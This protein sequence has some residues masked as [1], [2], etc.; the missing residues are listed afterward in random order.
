MASTV[1]NDDTQGLRAAMR[2]HTTIPWGTTWFI[3]VHKNNRCVQE[4][5]LLIP[6]RRWAKFRMK[7][8]LRLYR[9]NTFLP[10]RRS[11]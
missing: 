6:S 11:R 10:A 7:R 4:K 2:G 9:V 8:M 5:M 1:F 3:E